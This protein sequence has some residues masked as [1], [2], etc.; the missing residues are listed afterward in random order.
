[1]L[2]AAKRFQVGSIQS[3]QAI[4]F[5]EIPLRC[6]GSENLDLFQNESLSQVFRRELEN[7]G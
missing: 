4:H 2:A 1:M 7:R 5:G 3:I 6:F